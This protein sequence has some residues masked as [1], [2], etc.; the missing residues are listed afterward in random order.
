MQ[1]AWPGFYF[2]GTTSQRLPATIIPTP[3][4]LQIRLGDKTLLWPYRSFRQTLG[5]FSGEPVRFE[6][7]VDPTE[8]IVIADDSCLELIR[9][10]ASSRSMKFH[11]PGARRMR[12]FWIAS[13]AVFTVC[14]VAAAY[15]WGIPAAARSAASR[16]PV[17]WE[18]QLG[19]M[20]ADRFTTGMEICENGE[21]DAVTGEIL[22]R[23]EEAAGPQPYP[24]TVTIVRF[25]HAN[26]LAAPGGRIII[27]SG[28]LKLTRR[29]EE[30]AA[31]MAHEVV[32]VEKRHGLQLLFQQV[33][34]KTLAAGIMGDY[35]GSAS[36]LTE[37]G[38]ILGR[39]AYSRGHERE[40]DRVGMELLDSAGMDPAAMSEFFDSLSAGTNDFPEAL[41]YLSTH[42]NLSERIDVLRKRSKA[43]K[44]PYAPMFP[45]L[46]WETVRE[47]C[48]KS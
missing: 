6:K 48:S 28:L 3:H 22:K 35:S 18:V 45:D 42:P 7:G 37:G 21:I 41:K 38:K 8:T 17:K 4:G 12:P 26:A 11:N 40:A 9:R 20:T 5:S 14:I 13:A 2:D 47:A 43:F 29:P 23:L 32:H 34:L 46:E 10:Y 30:L 1:S 16:V 36:V 24:F 15:L 44:G 31:V 33:A 39:T 19:R 25:P 27:Y